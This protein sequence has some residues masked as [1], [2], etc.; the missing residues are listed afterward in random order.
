[1][2]EREFKDNR[3]KSKANW[4]IY[5]WLQKELRQ[6]DIKTARGTRLRTWCY[7]FVGSVP[8]TVV[9]ERRPQESNHREL[10]IYRDSFVLGSTV[11]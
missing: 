5:V 10:P 7:D 1:M 6:Q 3:K 9:R 11:W 4:T 8:R 2:V